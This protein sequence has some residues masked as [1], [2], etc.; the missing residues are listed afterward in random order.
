MKLYVAATFLLSVLPRFVSGSTF[1]DGDITFKVWSPCIGPVDEPGGIIDG[2]CEFDLS[3]KRRNLRGLKMDGKYYGVWTKCKIDD[4]LGTSEGPYT[5][6]EVVTSVAD[7]DYDKV[8]VDGRTEYHVRTVNSRLEILIEGS[9]ALVAK[10]EKKFQMTL[11][12]DELGKKIVVVDWVSTD[13][14]DFGDC[15]QQ[16]SLGGEGIYTNNKGS[17]KSRK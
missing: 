12:E 8:E 7:Y 17:G 2:D 16:L 4:D 5:L 15:N 14:V 11:S 9:G 10:G 1:E 3:D 6:N 13:W